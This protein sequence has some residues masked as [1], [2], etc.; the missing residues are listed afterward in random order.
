MSSSY[1]HSRVLPAIYS[2]NA[3]PRPDQVAVLLSLIGLTATLDPSTQLARN[4]P[5]SARTYVDSS[6]TCLVAG[7]LFTDTTLEA[8][9]TLSILGAC[10]LNAD[11]KR[12]PDANF[13]IFG[14]AMRLCIIAG[15]HRDPALIHPDMPLEEMDARR[16][17]WH[18]LLGSD[19]LHVSII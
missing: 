9:I 16:R 17:I 4:L 6:W 14:L 2:N 8:L 3:S 13:A 10:L 5:A 18:E 11:D 1:F 19:R 7:R 12:S 15:Y